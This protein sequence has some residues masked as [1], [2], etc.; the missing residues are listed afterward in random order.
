MRVP[1][2][3]LLQRGVLVVP[4]L[5]H[6]WPADFSSSLTVVL[7]HTWSF[8]DLTA[9]VCGDGIADMLTQQ[10]GGS[11]VAGSS[12]NR[13]GPAVNCGVYLSLKYELASPY[14]LG[15]VVCSCLVWD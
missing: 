15:R 9:G 10:Y 14:K 7:G 1:L 8:S 13:R 4:Q 5:E 12:M 6:C 2:G 11:M 3:A